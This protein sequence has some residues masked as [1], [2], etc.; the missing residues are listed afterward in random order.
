MLVPSDLSHADTKH[1]M[2]S[3]VTYLAIGKF[4]DINTVKPVSIFAEIKLCL[5]DGRHKRL[6]SYDRSQRKFVPV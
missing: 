2:W 4:D 1:K 3:N 5:V 6:R